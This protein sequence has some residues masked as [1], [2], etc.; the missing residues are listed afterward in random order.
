MN[1]NPIVSFTV[2]SDA[3]Q[4]GAIGVRESSFLVLV[5]GA[6]WSIEV[7]PPYDN[8]GMVLG[9]IT[10]ILWV[11]GDPTQGFTIKLCPQTPT[12]EA[13]SL[14]VVGPDLVTPL[15]GAAFVA[16]VRLYV[17]GPTS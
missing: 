1:G 13:F 7:L 2:S 17:N 9:Q 8:S 4:P 10:P 3:L 15:P 14:R 12:P 6:E 16:G 5:P 11:I